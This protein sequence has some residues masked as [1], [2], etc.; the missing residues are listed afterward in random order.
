MGAF[1]QA[2]DSSYQLFST[3]RVHSARLSARLSTP[4][5]SPS[6]R[7]ECTS[8]PGAI[9]K[10]PQ[11][12]K[13]N[14]KRHATRAKNACRSAERH[15]KRTHNA[16]RMLF[17]S[18][19][20]YGPF[21]LCSRTICMLGTFSMSFYDFAWQKKEQNTCKICFILQSSCLLY[22]SPSPRDS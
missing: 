6:L 16:C 11:K 8:L 18:D 19:M 3:T 5:F 13:T 17:Y 21:L 4:H 12:S 7:R 14:H 22:T 2:F 1:R 10:K 20:H 15:A 9:S